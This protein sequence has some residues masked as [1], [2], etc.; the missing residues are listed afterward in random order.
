MEENNLKITAII[1]TKNAEDTICE[2][3]ESIKE[4]D[5][6]IIVDEHSTDDTIEIA[7]EYKT[8]I[9][10]AD[11][12]NLL[13]GLNQALEQATGDWIFIVEQDEIIP[14]RLLNEV[15]R[16]T[17]SPKKNRFSISF[18]QQ[19]F[20]LGKEV[21]SQRKKNV[22]RLFKKE[23]CNFKNDFSTDLILK[24]GKIHK[25]NSNFK[26]QNCCILKFEK[27]EISR[28][29]VEI[30]EKNRFIS[31]NSKKNSSIFLKP[32]FTFLNNYFLKGGIFDG[33]RGFIYAKESYIEELILQIT[34]FEKQRSNNDFW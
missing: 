32:A 10:F 28:R 13:Q 8:K 26:I 6:I 18:A 2:T 12:N 9:I 4:L 22:L 19:T 5:E 25:I 7:K 30:I 29:M 15:L 24:K 14:Q 11:K 21:K 16:Y 31:K 20:Y 34:N 23:F 27:R 33:T 3:L 1:K 17:E